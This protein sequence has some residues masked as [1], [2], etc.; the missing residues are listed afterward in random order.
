M[1]SFLIGLLITAIAL[2]SST[3]IVMADQTPE[4]L[5]RKINKLENKVSKK[6]SKTFC[7]STGFGISSEGALKFAI[8]E[9]KNEFTRNPLIAEVDSEKIKKQIL[10]DIGDTCYFFELTKGDLDDFSLKNA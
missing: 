5:E 9:T 10:I 6:F 4:K 3:P 2:F 7:N 1:K 8:G